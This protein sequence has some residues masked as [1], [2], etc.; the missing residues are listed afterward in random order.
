MSFSAAR[1]CLLYL[2]ASAL[3]V[4]ADVAPEKVVAFVNQTVNLPCRTGRKS[5]L[6]TVEWSKQGII[7]LLYRH[8]SE[9]VEEKDRTFL[10]RTS[11]PQQGKQGDFSQSISDLRPSDAGWYQCRTMVGKE[12]LVEARLELIVG[13]V[14]EPKLTFV[15]PGAGGGVTLECRAERWIPEPEVTFYDAKG[16]EMEAEQPRTSLDS[17][18]F[19][20]TRR[21]SLQTF[22]NGVTCGVNQQSLNQTRK[23]DLYIPDKCME[24]CLKSNI[25]CVLG[26]IGVLVV[27][28]VPT[29]LAM[30]HGGCSCREKSPSTRTVGQSLYNTQGSGC[31][32]QGHVQEE[33]ENLKLRISEKDKM[34]AKLKTEIEKLKS[35]RSSA[36]QQDQP[37]TDPRSSLTGSKQVNRPLDHSNTPPAATSTSHNSKSDNIS[38]TNVSK[39]TASGPHLSKVSLGKER[40][41]STSALTNN[42][43]ASSSSSSAST[44]KESN[45]SRSSSFSGSRPGPVKS[46]RRYSMSNNRFSVLAEQSEESEHLIN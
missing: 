38:K 18:Y 45:I 21:L 43:A 22:T 14:S 17:E 37:A 2:V 19:T 28:A 30:K 10:N 20:V 1:L 8:G 32:C 16:K 40:P 3:R 25:C 5:D 13:A 7:T 4:S 23:A 33:N 11:L 12:V 15:P 24:S 35:Q 27:C 9:T 26:T 29:F 34:I 44:S 31:T 36:P 6:L 42:G 46:P 39:P 41:K